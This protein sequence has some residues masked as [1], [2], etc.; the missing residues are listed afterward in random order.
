MD[1]YHVAALVIY[2]LFLGAAILATI[3]FGEGNF[4]KFKITGP[5]QVGHQDMYTSRDGIEC[6][7][8]YPMDRDEYDKTIGQKGRNTFWFRNGY[9]SRLGAV[10]ATS[11]WDTEDHKHPWF[12][13]FLDD[14]KL[15]TVQDGL[16]AKEF[17]SGEKKLIPIIFCHGLA[18][19][20][21]TYSGILRDLASHGYI[22]FT[23]SHFDGTANMSKKKDGTTIYWTSKQPHQEIEYR[24]K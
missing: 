15:D 11:S 17:S 6:S 5:Y 18:G 4:A 24:R 21:T 10:K 7:C 9:E 1:V 20:R 2:C 12:Y 13:K 19:S 8:F 16:L 14:C 23:L 22:I 3:L